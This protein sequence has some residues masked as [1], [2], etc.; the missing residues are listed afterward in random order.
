MLHSLIVSLM[1]IVNKTE[2]AIYISF[3]FGL[4]ALEGSTFLPEYLHN[5]YFL[6]LTK[7]NNKI[8]IDSS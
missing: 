2:S 6:I 7:N 1:N 4:V 5:S 8:Y 3:Y